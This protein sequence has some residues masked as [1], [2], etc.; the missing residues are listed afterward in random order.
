MLSRYSVRRG[1]GSQATIFESSLVPDK[2]RRIKIA[3]EARVDVK[4]IL[5]LFMQMVHPLA[6]GVAHGA[7]G[8]ENPYR[9][10]PFAPSM[11]C[12]GRGA[13]CAPFSEKR[14]R[15]ACG[16]APRFTKGR[17][18]M[19]TSFPIMGKVVPRIPR[20]SST[21]QSPEPECVVDSVTYRLSSF[22]RFMARNLPVDKSYY[23]ILHHDLAHAAPSGRE[24]CARQD[25][26]GSAIRLARSFRFVRTP[27]SHRRN[28]GRGPKGSRSSF[29]PR[30]SADRC[31]ARVARE[32]GNTVYTCG[33]TMTC[34]RLLL[35]IA[36]ELATG[37]R[38][39][40]Q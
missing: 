11:L 3:D 40:S 1:L 37:N 33:Y 35:L 18:G 5:H 15:R 17:A 9:V 22:Y 36:P 6:G 12:S 23:S 7:A 27:A 38:R 8:A 14:N 31:N 39:S 21:L 25:Q 4:G 30:K 26:N 19:G 13:G 10:P 32:G 28:G 2:R 29:F 34:F 20:F 16:P 24:G